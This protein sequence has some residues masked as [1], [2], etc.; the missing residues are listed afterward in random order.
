MLPTHCGGIWTGTVG[1]LQYW[2]EQHEF[3]R[4]GQP[5]LYYLLLVPLYEFLPS[6]AG[7]RRDALA[8]H[9]TPSLLLVSACTGQRSAC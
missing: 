2:I 4:G 3:Q 9:S 6:D 8:P 7:V 5:D 1:A